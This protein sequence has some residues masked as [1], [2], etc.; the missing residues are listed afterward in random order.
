MKAEPGLKRIPK[1]VKRFSDKNA[2]Q[3]KNPEHQSDPIRSKSDLKRSTGLTRTAFQT[4]ARTPLKPSAPTS[5]KAALKAVTLRVLDKARREAEAAGLDLTEW[6]DQFLTEVGVR[7]K[8]YGRAFC[9]PDKGQLSGTL[10]LRQGLKLKEIRKKAKTK[11][12]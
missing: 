9:D 11:A 4:K 3:N 1:S 6:E 5:D 2:H 7:V 8:T 12:K 10:S